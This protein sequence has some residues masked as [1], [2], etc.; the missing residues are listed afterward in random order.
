ME[1][2]C[3]CMKIEI[4]TCHIGISYRLEIGATEHSK[5]H[6][7]GAPKPFKGVNFSNV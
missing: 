2:G 7:S 6:E 3:D 1:A 4:M 5:Q